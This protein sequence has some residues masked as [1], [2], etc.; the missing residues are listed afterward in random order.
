[1]K[2]DSENIYPI[3]KSFI[4][5]ED[6][7]KLKNQ[8][9]L[10]RI[11]ESSH[12]DLNCP[13]F[14]PELAQLELLLH[15]IKINPRHIPDQADRI[16]LNP[17]LKLFFSHWNLVP[18]FYNDQKTGKM[19][20]A[21]DQWIMIWRDI[22]S[23]AVYLKE[24]SEKE[25][26][27]VKVIAEDIPVETAARQSNLTEGK[28]YAILRQA[29]QKQLLIGPPSLITRQKDRSSTVPKI[30]DSFSA[31]R[32]F[33]LQ[34]HIT[35]TCDLH[36]KHCYDR[37][38]K[39]SLSL[40]QGVHIL[41]D[42]V[43]F[44][45]QRHVS[46]HICFTGGNPFLYPHFFAL[47]QAAAD[48]GFTTSILGNP[49]PR[50]QLERMIDI[51]YPTYFQVSLEGL[52][53]HN[54]SIRGQ[55][56]FQRV[57]QFLKVLRDLHIPKSVMLTL[58][59]DNMDE[60]LPL[61]DQLTDRVDSFTFNRLSQVGKGENLALPTK[62]KYIEFLK[63]YVEQA[64]HNPIIRFKDNL[65]NIVL[66]KHGAEL[67]GGCTGHGC[68]AAFNFIA[69]LPDGEA[70]ACRKFPSPIGNILRDPLDKVYDS[71]LARR[72]RRG[73]EACTG[74]SLHPVCGGCLATAYSFGLD[75]F[76]DKDP[77]CFKDG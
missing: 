36:C 46:G 16:K 12:Q 39:S 53:E 28:V 15:K 67:C 30:V 44:C 2:I 77:F 38:K 23:R 57:I 40:E 43:L 69:V 20:Q 25:L 52:P 58:T 68:G 32:T 54:D 61:A 37:S 56:Q 63:D 5:S 4:N 3:C 64:Q 66:E 65:I 10:A 11:L 74:C 55:G 48:R 51:Q 17:S 41:D 71:D 72:Y 45:R 7:E 60:V 62:E 27:A 18:L 49:T 76:H 50:D 73:S 42:F 26:F 21:G 29:V 75:I 22:H 59:D 34:W 47:Y 13:D 31:A 33:T 19:P 24:A 8:D 9:D 14:L 35:H 70:H 6:W 1:M